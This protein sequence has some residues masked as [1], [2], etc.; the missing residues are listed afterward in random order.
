MIK[1][2]EP[3]NLIL[4]LWGNANHYSGRSLDGYQE[5]SRNRVIKKVPL[6]FSE[7]MRRGVHIKTRI[8][9]VHVTDRYMWPSRWRCINEA[10]KHVTRSRNAT[11]WEWE[12]KFIGNEIELRYGDTEDQVSDEL[13]IEWQREWGTTISWFERLY[14]WNARGSHGHPGPSIDHWCQSS[15][16]HV[17][18]VSEPK[19]VTLKGRDA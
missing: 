16:D 4:W 10:C 1:H 17:R 7:G 2:R 6:R 19:D 11:T 5:S 3:R 9:L 14:S 12:N 8:C 15:L 18:S 13:G